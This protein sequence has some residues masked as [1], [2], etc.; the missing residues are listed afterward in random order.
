MKKRLF[1]LALAIVMLFQC[2][3]AAAPQGLISSDDADLLAAEDGVK[4][5]YTSEYAYVRGGAEWREKNWHDI[6]AER[7][8]EP[9][10]IMKNGKS[11][12]NVTRLALLKFDISG[13]KLEDVG[14]VSL[15]VRLTD[16]SGG[17]VPF[18][19]Y[20]VGSNWSE[21]MVTYSTQPQKISNDP[22]ATDFILK[23]V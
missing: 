15:A 10:L 20:Y 18:E 13:L 11:G 6:L 17:G 1:V 12:G 8:K 4:T 3:C 9:M 16:V 7:G 23:K 14:S 5:L 2:A 22:V 19:V 21:S